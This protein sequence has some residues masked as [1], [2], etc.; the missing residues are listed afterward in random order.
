MSG[1]PGGDGSSARPAKR[2]AWDGTSQNTPAASSSAQRYTNPQVYLELSFSKLHMSCSIS[3]LLKFSQFSNYNNEDFTNLPEQIVS[4]LT[5]EQVSQHVLELPS[6]KPCTLLWLFS[7]QEKLKILLSKHMA[8]HHALLI[9][10]STEVENIFDHSER[11]IPRL[12]ED[13]TK[14]VAERA[15]NAHSQITTG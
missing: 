14:L 5:A 4:F 13:I 2:P 7:Y 8:E 6:E 10:A 11:F 1:L 15:H 9:N 12:L 3:F